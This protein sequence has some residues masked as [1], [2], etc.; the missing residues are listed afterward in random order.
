MSHFPTISDRRMAWHL[1][2][3]RA[4]IGLR[5][6]LRVWDFLDYFWVML[7]GEAL[8]N[9]STI[10]EKKRLNIFQVFFLWL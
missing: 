6:D 8:V 2:I 9:K 5:R 3:F 1:L 7:L 4:A 10:K